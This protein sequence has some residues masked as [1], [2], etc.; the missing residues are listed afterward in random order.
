MGPISCSVRIIHPWY[1]FY[2]TELI[3]AVLVPF[4]QHGYILPAQEERLLAGRSGYVPLPA[5]RHPLPRL[6]FGGV[7]PLLQRHERV[8]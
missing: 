2:S 6:P 3:P 7:R 8:E 4:F 1:Q 5:A